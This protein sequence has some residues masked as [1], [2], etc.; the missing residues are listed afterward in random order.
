MKKNYEKIIVF[1]LFCIVVSVPAYFY[2][3]KI[4]NGW[5]NSRVIND[6]EVLDALRGNFDRNYNYTELFVWEHQHLNFSWDDIERHTN[7]IEI[8]DYGRGRCGEFAILYTALCRANGYDS[9]L[10]VNIFG[11]HA[12]TQIRINNTWIHFDASL[13]VND[14]RVMQPEIYERD[15]N[16]APILALAFGQS[17]IEDVTSQYRS[18]LL[19][20]INQMTGVLIL[21]F[22]LIFFILTN[23]WIRGKFYALYFLPKRKKLR[24]IRDYY[25]EGLRNIGNFFENGLRAFYILRLLV[26]FFLPLSIGLIFVINLDSNLILSLFVMGLTL[27]AFSVVELPSLTKPRVFA[28]LIE[29][30]NSK[31]F[32][33][34]YQ[35]GKSCK[36]RERRLEFSIKEKELPLSFR[37]QNLNFH[38]LKNCTIWITF[39]DNLRPKDF[40]TLKN[41]DFSKKY[42]IQIRNNAVKFSPLDSY[43]TMTPE[44]CLVLPLKVK[45]KTSIDILKTD[46]ISIE[47]RSETTWG[48]YK[49][50]F[51]V[52]YI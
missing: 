15:W 6:P 20:N 24:K 30:C 33:C 48:S 18:G 2:G 11:D 42:S 8:L 32:M 27:V 5:E 21:I 44:D 51:P 40:K 13:D 3:S 47:I 22:S 46:E 14:S 43:L 10:V 34:R 29:D 45:V 38:T 25:E 39:P 35:E 9:R 41:M 52:K 16:N 4:Y 50:T 7:P 49:F 31:K 1:V 37:I 12:W 26:S 28:S 36:Y 19:N 23:S 17:G